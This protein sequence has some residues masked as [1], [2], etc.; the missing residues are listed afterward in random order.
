MSTVRDCAQRSHSL[1][2]RRMA[3]V[4]AGDIAK[5]MGIS[6]SAMS[7]LKNKHAESVLV[8]LAHLGLK[9]VAASSRCL[10]PAAFEF[11]TR[12]HERMARQSPQLLWEDTE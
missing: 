7:E 12:T 10:D 5:D 6:D 11:L 9:A 8:L 4:K 3:A 2:L 1:F